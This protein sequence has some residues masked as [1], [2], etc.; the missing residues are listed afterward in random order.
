MTVE[1]LKKANDLQSESQEFNRI[2][3]CSTERKKGFSLSIKCI[4]NTEN[5]NSEI[6]LPNEINEKVKLFIS[7]VVSDRLCELRDEF[8]AL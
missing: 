8:N 7:K 2:L 4:I 3:D 6:H 5:E 1:Q